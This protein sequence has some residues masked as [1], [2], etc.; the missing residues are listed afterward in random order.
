MTKKPSQDDGGDTIQRRL[1]SIQQELK[2]P[3]NQLNS[4]GGFNYRSQEDILEAVKPC[5]MKHELVLTLSDNM[6]NMEGRVYVR[7]TACLSDLAGAY[8]ISVTAYAR[9]EL[10]R[11]GMDSSQITGTASSYARKYA[12]GGLFLIDD[13]RDA[14]TIE[15]PQELTGTKAVYK[16]LDILSDGSHSAGDVH[17]YMTDIDA[18]PKSCGADLPDIAGSC[19]DKVRDRIIANPSG[20]RGAVTKHTKTKDSK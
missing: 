13:N 9:E 16:L 11:K 4:F 19:S 3:K 12:L 17:S 7:A 8:H 14:D 5:L 20:F 2:S 1:L 6:E 18:I 15:T 10:T